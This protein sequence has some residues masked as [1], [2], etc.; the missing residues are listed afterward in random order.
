MLLN[1]QGP[2]WQILC[3][4]PDMAFDVVKLAI[5]QVGVRKSQSVP[6][7]RC[8]ILAQRGRLRGWSQAGKSSRMPSQE[9]SYSKAMKPSTSSTLLLDKWAV[10]LCDGWVHC[11]RLLKCPMSTLVTSEPPRFDP[12][13]ASRA[14]RKLAAYLAYLAYLVYL[15]PTRRRAVSRRSARKAKGQA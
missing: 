2:A 6:R 4:R 10:A 11:L 15:A 13:L 14:K 5:F 3:L 1:G 7:R 9:P 12:M 8:R